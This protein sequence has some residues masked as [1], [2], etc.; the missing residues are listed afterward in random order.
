MQNGRLPSQLKVCLLVN[1][2]F[3]FYSLHSKLLNGTKRYIING[4][5]VSHYV[6]VDMSF[7]A[8]HIAAMR[9]LDTNAPFNPTNPYLSSTNQEGFSVFG[10][11]MITSMVAEVA[12]QALHSAWYQKWMV[13]RR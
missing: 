5:D 6:H 4:R 9:L 11:Q 2:I 1:K 13:H 7:Q 12:N 3:L 10:A 8:Y